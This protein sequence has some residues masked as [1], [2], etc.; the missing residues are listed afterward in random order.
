MPQ[1]AGFGMQQP[2]GQGTMQGPSQ[3]AMPAMQGAWP[4]TM[5]MGMN[6]GQ[7]RFM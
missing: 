7:G 5:Q 4:G 3:P 6:M 2:P 1:F